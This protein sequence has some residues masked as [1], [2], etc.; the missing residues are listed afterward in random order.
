MEERGKFR[1]CLHGT[2]LTKGTHTNPD[3]IAECPLTKKAKRQHRRI[4]KEKRQR[5]AQRMNEMKRRKKSE[6]IA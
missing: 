5:Q 2:C 4:V 6:K 3:L 1:T